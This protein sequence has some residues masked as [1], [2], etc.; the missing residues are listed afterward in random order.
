[1]TSEVFAEWLRRQGTEVIRTSAGAWHAQGPRVYQAFPYHVLLTPRD[2][3]LQALLRGRGGVGLRYST[4]LTA[5]AG[6]LS[7]HVVCDDRDYGLDRLSPWSRKSVRRGLR[8]CRV[9]PITF[10]RLAD[11]GW[12]LQRDTL[13]RQGRSRGPTRQAWRARCLAA[14]DLPGFAA[15]GTLAEGELVASAT[16]CRIDD[17]VYILSQQSA[18]EFLSR[19]VNSVLAFVLTRATLRQPGVRAILYG[20]HSLDAP[21]SVDRFKFGMGYTARPVRQRVVF[22][23]GLAPAFNAAT[24]GLLR[25]ARRAAPRSATLAK[26]EGMVRF[27]RLGRLPLRRQPLPPGLSPS[28]VGGT[29]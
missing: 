23:A 14:V 10:E 9:E 3:D 21:P 25:L 11:E 22:R 6:C 16:T 13:D 24:H 15:W 4:P 12:R 26:A 17:W 28:A 29:A 7:Y 8:D 20:V 1:V 19:Q 5:G 27:Y 18:R 2:E